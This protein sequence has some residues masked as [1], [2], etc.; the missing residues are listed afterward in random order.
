MISIDQ[1]ARRAYEAW[2][3]AQARANGKAPATWERLP[4]TDQAAW[5]TAVQVVR[6]ELAA[7]H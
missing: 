2:V 4:V 7:V 1:I 5:I 6:H 3:T